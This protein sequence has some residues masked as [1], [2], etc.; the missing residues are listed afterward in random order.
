MTKV[1][2]CI[3]AGVACWALGFLMGVWL[4][5]C[6]GV[7][8]SCSKCKNEGKQIC[9]VCCSYMGYPDK[10]DPKPKSRGEKI[11]SMSDAELAAW[12]QD[13]CPPGG[14]ICPALISCERCWFDWLVEE[15]DV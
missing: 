6:G 11:R 2:A 14:H 12:L 10:F 7:M 9:S 3:I 13:G 4:M 5:K 8:E 1:C 15:G